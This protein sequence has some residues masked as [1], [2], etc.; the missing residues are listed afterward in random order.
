VWKSHKAFCKQ[1]AEPF[2]KVTPRDAAA[3]AEATVVKDLCVLVDGMG[4]VGPGGD[5]MKGARR[6]LLNAGA[7]V[8]VIDATKGAKIPEQVAAMLDCKDA[9]PSSLIMLGWGSGDSQ[10]ELDFAASNVFRAAATRW[11][12]AGGRFM[13]QGERVALAGNWPSWFDKSW[14]SSDYFRTDHKCFA[15]DESNATNSVQQK[16]W[17]EWYKEAKGAVTSGY[18]VKACMLKDV[19]L[20]DILFG[21]EEGAASYSLVPGFGGQSI[22]AGQVAIAFS[23][24]EAGT[25]SFFGDVNYEDET[26]KIMAILARGK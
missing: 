26:L 14:S 15:A 20:E 25:V 2:I 3:V 16:H 21:T 7:N 13:V 23:R 5:Y 22:G 9:A 19:E 12:R 10:S 8:A 4:P 1:L 17:C 11:C 24:F 6:A 18:N